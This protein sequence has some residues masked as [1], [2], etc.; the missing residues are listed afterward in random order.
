[1]PLHLANKVNKEVKGRAVVTG[2]RRGD[3]GG[4]TAEEMK[5]R[6]RNS[7]SWR[8]NGD[9]AQMVGFQ[10]LEVQFK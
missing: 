5:K 2:R 8:E 6:R 4:R 10:P 1:M 7:D 3:E 9:R